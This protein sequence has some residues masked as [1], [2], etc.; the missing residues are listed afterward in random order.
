MNATN[1]TKKLIIEKCF[2]NIIFHCLRSRRDS[3]GRVKLGTNLLIFVDALH[4]YKSNAIKVMLHDHWNSLLWEHLKVEMFL[5]DRRQY[6]RYKILRILY[7]CLIL[8]Q[9]SGSCVRCNAAEILFVIYSVESKYLTQNENEMKLY[10]KAIS[11]LLKDSNQQVCLIA[12][13]V[14]NYY[15]L[16]IYF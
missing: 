12:I 13:N 2:K 14:D 11:Q 8:F 10:T 9:A 1:K 7:L 5:I 4:R 16:Y 15:I 3:T 6:N